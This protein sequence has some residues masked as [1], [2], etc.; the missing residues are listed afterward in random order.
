[1]SGP[2]LAGAHLAR[3]AQG[4]TPAW[5]WALTDSSETP[6]Q[7]NVT[8][9]MPCHR[10]PPHSRGTSR[11]PGAHPQR[12]QVRNQAPRL[13][14]LAAAVD[15]LE[16]DERAPAAS[17]R[18]APAGP[19]H[20]PTACARAAPGVRARRRSYRSSQ[21]RCA[22]QHAIVAL[23]QDPANGF[24]LRAH[25]ANPYQASQFGLRPANTNQADA[26]S[27][28]SRAD[29]RPLA[30]AARHARWCC[31]PVGAAGWGARRCWRGHRGPERAKLR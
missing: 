10:T 28:S 21:P 4:G 25:P 1:M 29:Q 24:T 31:R 27:D 23:G 3:A 18:G 5:D 20:G 12:A 22:A 8:M 2:T 15:A 30:S 13:G 26:R 16:Q 11:A 17:L 6:G 7:R 19:A 9:P 14:G